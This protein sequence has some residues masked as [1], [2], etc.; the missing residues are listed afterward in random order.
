M[1]QQITIT[2]PSGVTEHAKVL[3]PAFTQYPN[4]RTVAL[5]GVP[6]AF[7][8]GTYHW[9]YKGKS[10]I[11]S[12]MTAGYRFC[13]LSAFSVAVFWLAKRE[14]IELPIEAIKEAISNQFPGGLTEIIPT[15]SS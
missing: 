14:P 2:I 9:L 12:A 10:M 4:W 8:V 1:S 13:Q 11:E 3:I 15:Q 5:V 6:V 7:G